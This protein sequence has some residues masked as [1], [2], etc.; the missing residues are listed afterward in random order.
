MCTTSRFI[1][2]SVVKV[3]LVSFFVLTY[4][5]VLRDCTIILIKFESHTTDPFEGDVLNKI[6]SIFKNEN[7]WKK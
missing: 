5:L 1:Y 4:C 2:I 7:D 6:F 3:R